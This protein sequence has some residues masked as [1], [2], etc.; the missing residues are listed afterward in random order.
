MKKLF[1]PALILFVVISFTLKPATSHSQTVDLLGGN[2]LNGAVTGALLGAGVM[3]LQNNDDFAPLRIGVGAGILGGA[4]I[5]AYDIITLPQG[6]QFF[7]SGVFN[8]GNNS[9]I[10]ILLDTMYG[11]ATGGVLGS[12][13][14]LIQN[15]PLVKGLQY[16][17]SAGAWV[18]FGF[19]LIDAF[20]LSERNSD[21]TASSIFNRS[22]II[23]TS[24]GPLDLGFG[25]PTVYHTLSLDH[26]SNGI[27]YAPGFKFFSI[28]SRF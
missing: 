26:N 18:G 16:G 15:K 3:G 23:E 4:G 10:L 13:V 27:D 5:A 11:A 14:M 21:F 12:A 2:I 19:G 24:A 6:Q 17:G 25:E 20:T 22:S 28:S 8:D 9:S 1:L 7:I